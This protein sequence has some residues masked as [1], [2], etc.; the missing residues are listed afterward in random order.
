MI[1]IFKDDDDKD[2]VLIS[3]GHGDVG[4]GSGFFLDNRNSDFFMMWNQ[5]PDVIGKT[6]SPRIEEEIPILIDFGKPECIDVF[7]RELEK[8]KKD[9]FGG[10]NNNE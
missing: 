2:R 8:H 9:K 10:A 7:I 6:K 4:F 1:N 3:M 5:E